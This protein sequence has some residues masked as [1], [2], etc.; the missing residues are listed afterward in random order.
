MRSIA[1]MSGKWMPIPGS[2][3]GQQTWVGDTPPSRQDYINGGFP[4]QA[5]AQAEAMNG[6]GSGRVNQWGIEIPE[7]IQGDPSRLYIG[8]RVQGLLGN[9]QEPDMRGLEA[10][11]QEAMRTGLGKGSLL[12]MEKNKLDEAQQ[13]DFMARNTAGEA[14]GARSQLAMRGGLGGG[15]ATSINKG[16]IRAGLAGQQKIGADA[17]SGRLQIGMQDEANRL[18][19]LGNLGAI[20]NQ[21]AK[22]GLEK[23]KIGA[24]GYSNDAS[25]YQSQLNNQNNWNRANYQDAMTLYGA[26][27]TAQAT[28]NSGKK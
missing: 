9:V 12:A 28:A 27:K 25:I 10:N 11:R 17:A 2:A 24:Q 13:R 16:A 4:T 7:Y 26:E 19:Q 21:Y 14:A 5:W 8:D 3:S 20:E 6:R 23:A 22:T 1:N 18:N 15:Q